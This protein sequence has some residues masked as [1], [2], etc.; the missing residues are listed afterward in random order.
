MG[1]F[2]QIITGLKSKGIKITIQRLAIIDFLAN[3][4]IHPTAEDIYSEVKKDFSSMS[5]ATVYNTLEKLEEIGEI[6][7]LRMSDKKFNYEYNLLPHNHFY[8]K[9][10]K[11]ILDIW[12]E[13]ISSKNE[14]D[15]HKIE[16]TQVC[17]K[18]YCKECR[19]D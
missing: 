16:E 2:K 4:P 19:V 7:K 11:R 14:I 10:C 9:K 1:S 8:C 18:G 6:I 12:K 13:V 5:L 17:Y 15:G 3:N